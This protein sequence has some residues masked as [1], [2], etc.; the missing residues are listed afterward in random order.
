[1]ATRLSLEEWRA[2]YIAARY[3][4]ARVFPTLIRDVVH[5][6][7]YKNQ[8][9]N[10]HPNNLFRRRLPGSTTHILRYNTL[11]DKPVESPLKRR[12]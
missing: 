9:H 4:A 12:E 2:V 6:K 7:P 10:L 3:I 1:M 11:C 5:E 8:I